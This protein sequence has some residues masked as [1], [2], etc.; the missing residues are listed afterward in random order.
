MVVTPANLV[1]YPTAPP[2]GGF[3]KVD[4]SGGS[5]GG[6]VGIVAGP[7]GSPSG[8]SL[9]LT[10]TGNS[11][12]WTVLTNDDSG[13]ALSAIT[14]LSYSTYTNSGTGG[15]DLQLIIDPGAKSGTAPAACPASVSYASMNF[16]P[17]LQSGSYSAVTPSAWQSWN[18]LMGGGADA[19]VWA[20]GGIYA[21]G[22]APESYIGSGGVS[23]NTFLSY[24]PNAAILPD[25]SGGGFGVNV[26]SGWGVTSG[27]VDALSIGTSA[28]TTTYDFASNVPTGPGNVWV[29]DTSGTP[30]H[31]PS[32]SCAFPSE[33]TIQSA[34][35]DAAAGDTIYVCPG[36]YS[37]AINISTSKLTLDGAE[38]GVPAYTAPG[39]PR[40]DSESIIDSTTGITYS[41]SGLTGE[42]VDG[43]DMYGYSGS[44]PGEIT[45]DPGLAGV[46]S[47]WTFTD[48]IIDASEGGIG[49]NTDGVASPSPTTI[50]GN[51]FV[52]STPSTESGGGWAGQAVTIW[53]GSGNNVTIDNNDFSDLSGPGGAI[54]TTGAGGVSSAACASDPSNGLSITDNTWE[55]DGV[56]GSASLPAGDENFVVLFCTSGASITGNTASITDAND[57]NAEGPIYLGGG[58]V[59]PVV[60][61][62]ILNG[63]GATV[64]GG[65]ISVA[66]QFY[67][68]DNA[69]IENNSIKG[70]GDSGTDGQGIV[71]YGGGQ[72]EP[73]GFTIENNTLTDNGYGIWIYNDGGSPSGTITGNNVNGSITTDCV[74]NSTGSGTDSTNDTWTSNVGTSS[75]P[76]SPTA[77]CGTAPSVTLQPVSQY[78]NSGQM[79]TFTSTASGYETPT[80]Q[81][82]VSTNHG[83]TWSNISGATSTTFTTGAN[84]GFENG[85]QVRAV[86]TNS[87]G[88]ASSNGAT[89]TLATAPVVTLQPVSQYYNSGQ[90]LTF[91]S[92]ASGGPTPT[93]QWQVSTN[94]GSTWSNIS[95]A[96]STTFTTGANNGFENGW[97]V[98]AVFTNMAGTANSNG[99]TETLATAPVVTLQPVS[100]TYHSG[101][102]LTFTSAASG[103]PA[104]TVQ[105][106]VSTNGGSSW[107][108]ISGATSTTFTT[109]ANNNFENGWQV[110][111]VFTNMAGTANSNGATETED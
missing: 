24:Y 110:R 68:T 43:F 77:L 20:T 48:N 64:P 100:Q 28:G 18:V 58:D 86:F 67:P 6:A 50:S 96:T 5:G 15:P 102:M 33:N 39:V 32:S 36:T 16:E 7:V 34:V 91:T 81:W 75:S 49:L 62:N 17:Y 90:M 61:G 19:E 26:G 54:N 105:W 4:Q 35:N 88:T 95:G 78:Y 42:T 73:T 101:Q 82:Q 60:S 30:T 85:W 11:S 71:V 92:T 74:D 40:I 45:A 89:E 12:H 70:W 21:S 66:T 2:V 109:G 3:T 8:G 93:V 13:T 41:G 72:G 94:H 47:G 52:Q 111:A 107:S 84:N 10:T 57:P 99:A 31:A 37:G 83:S 97:Q 25:T 29:V 103:G 9:Q 63:D 56:P 53:G 106:Q 44:G 69:T 14:A 27:N 76:D 55:G 79:L 65:A 108:N 59:S 1:T 22:C 23:W 98:R 87:S 46:G 38:F 104:P 80:V 51:E